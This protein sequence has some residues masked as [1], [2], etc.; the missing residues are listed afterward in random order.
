MGEKTD[1]KSTLK[2]IWRSQLYKM[3]T[4]QHVYLS[5]GNRTKM[6]ANP[7]V[8]NTGTVIAE[9]MLGSHEH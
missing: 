6:D 3:Y 4:I 7:K 9:T 1:R 5:V 8:L 2:L